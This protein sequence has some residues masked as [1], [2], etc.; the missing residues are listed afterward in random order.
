MIMASL[1][2]WGR[3]WLRRLVATRFRLRA[4]DEEPEKPEDSVVYV[5]GEKGSE[6]AALM[7]CPCRCGETIW[8]NLLSAP[9]RPV[10]RIQKHRRSQF[11]ISPSVWRQVGC[12]S[13]FLILRN[14]IE[15]CGGRSEQFRE[16]A[17]VARP[18]DRSE[19]EV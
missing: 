6:W 10:W 9:G 8:L 17:R 13:H 11:S 16:R 12:R 4:V 19:T 5:V 15:W 18:L 7:K 2:K 14:R 1:L 3:R